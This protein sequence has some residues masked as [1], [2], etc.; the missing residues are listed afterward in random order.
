MNCHYSTTPK[1]YLPKNQPSPLISISACATMAQNTQVKSPDINPIR[2]LPVNE[3]SKKG[4]QYTQI[5]APTKKS[6]ILSII[7]IAFH[8]TQCSEYYPYCQVFFCVFF[9]IHCRRA[10]FPA[11]FWSYQVSPVHRW[12]TNDMS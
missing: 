2:G 10:F 11:L 6:I 7:T 8:V 4:G 9:V 5:R 12:D 1:N 3:N